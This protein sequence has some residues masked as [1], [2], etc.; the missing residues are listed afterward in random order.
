[1][2][3]PP[4]IDL[5]DQA[6]RRILHICYGQM[7]RYGATRVGWNQ[8][9]YRGFIQNGHL[10]HFFSDRDVA[11]F[12][13]PFK[14]RDLGRNKANRR[15]IETAEAFE[16]D[17]IIL[18]HCDIITNETVQKIKST[19]DCAVIHCNN[20]PL[21]VPENVDKIH[22]RLKVCDHVFISTGKPTI[23]EFF[24][25]A[26]DRTHYLPN[27]VDPAIERFDASNLAREELERDLI[28]CGNSANHTTRGQRVQE[29]KATVDSSIRFE[30]FGLG[31]LPPIWG[32]DY[33]HALSKSAMGLNL[34]RQEG[35]YWY[36]SARI[37]QLGG[38]GLLVFTH[39][40]NHLHNLF[41]SETLVYYE[42]TAE[43]RDRIH[44]FATNDEA[45]R[46]RANRT[47]QYLHDH[48]SN[49]LTAHYLVNTAL[50]RTSVSVYRWS[51]T[52]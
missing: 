22:N 50:T 20:D 10:V 35:H 6:P 23:D 19:R 32:K 13:A 21:F 17:L 9:I 51:S 29:L 11:A 27:P 42:T 45:R 30:T 3:Q 39:R 4:S 41:P 1:M 5:S 49:R 40:D 34:N 25:D 28:F 15:L 46:T 44:F 48:S 47:R 7:R 31:G 37:A 8:K 16:P 38:N 52:L 12:E 26:K 24:P 43:L 36:S 33:D 2:H 18:G 14:L